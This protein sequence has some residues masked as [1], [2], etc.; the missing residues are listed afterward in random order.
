MSTKSIVPKRNSISVATS[1]INRRTTARSLSLS[2]CVPNVRSTIVRCPSVAQSS[3]S[4]ARRRHSKTFRIGSDSWTMATFDLCAIT[5]KILSH[6]KAII[7]C[8]C[9]C[10]WRRHWRC[11][12]RCHHQNHRHRRPLLR[13]L[14]RLLRLSHPIKRHLPLQLQSM[15]F[16]LPKVHA[17]QRRRHRKRTRI[18]Q[19][20]LK[21]ASVCPEDDDADAGGP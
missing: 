11:H 8:H 10:H 12:C 21:L 18:P 3:T 17:A 6:V 14:L 5:A 13:L 19:R 9:R 1:A 20:R 4:F 7:R 2:A 15:R 16:V